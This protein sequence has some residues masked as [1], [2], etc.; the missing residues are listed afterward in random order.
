MIPITLEDPA[1]FQER[2]CYVKPIICDP[3]DPNEPC[4]IDKD[5]EKWWVFDCDHVDPSTIEDFDCFYF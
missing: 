1:V 4:K 2:S 5:E 3:S